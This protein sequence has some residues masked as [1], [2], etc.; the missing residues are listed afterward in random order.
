VEPRVPIQKFE[1][2]IKFGE[3]I[4]KI[5]FQEM[6]KYLMKPDSKLFVYSALMKLAEQI[7]LTFMKIN[8]EQKAK[9]THV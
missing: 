7:F 6:E 1:M 9:D 4:S 2:R 3:K 8:C 5:N